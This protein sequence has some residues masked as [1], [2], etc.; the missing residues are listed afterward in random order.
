MADVF[1]PFYC[2][3]CGETLKTKEEFD[4]HYQEEMDAFNKRNE[5]S[6]EQ[7]FDLVYNENNY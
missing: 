6:E 7:V 2:T 5:L 3:F 4:K 1:H